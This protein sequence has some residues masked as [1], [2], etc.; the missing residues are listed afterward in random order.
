MYDMKNDIKF[1]KSGPDQDQNI[2]TNSK[3]HT[4]KRT[5]IEDIDNFHVS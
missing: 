1:E 2:M 5:L 3:N 4:S